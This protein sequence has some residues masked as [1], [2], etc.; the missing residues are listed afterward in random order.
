MVGPGRA[1]Q[2]SSFRFK[3][4]VVARGAE[5]LACGARSAF[6]E[7]VGVG[8]S[9]PRVDSSLAGSHNPRLSTLA[10]FSPSSPAA[11]RSPLLPPWRGPPRGAE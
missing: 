4:Q 8:E 10:P 6:R 3:S 1:G 11:L 2:R 7:G 5:P 9:E